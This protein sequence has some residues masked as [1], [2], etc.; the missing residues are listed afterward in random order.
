M[1]KKWLILFL[2]IIGIGASGAAYSAETE[3]TSSFVKFSSSEFLTFD[4][5]LSL[6]KNPDPSNPLAAKLYKFW[7]TPII[8]NEAYYEGV[9]APVRT[10]SKLGRMLRVASWNIEKSLKLKEAIGLLTDSENFAS[11]I[12]S[13]K[14]PV[15]SER[16]EKVLEQHHLLTQADIILCQEM[17]IGVK[18]SG[19]VNAPLE[20]AK[21]LHMNYA[22]APAYLEIDPAY[23]GTENIVLESG[24][25]DE[26]AMDFYRVDK[27]RYKGLFGSVVLSRYPIKSVTVFPLHNQGYDWYWGEQEKTTFFEESRRFGAKTLFQSEVHREMKVGGRNFMRVDLE[28]PGLPDNTLTIINI[29]LEIKCLPVAR[30]AQISEILE[31]IKG[32][33]NPVIMA[34]DFNSAPGDLSPTS[35]VRETARTLKR[36]TTW[37]TVGINAIVPQSMAVNVTRGISNV[38]KNFQNPTAKS[39]PIVAPNPSEKMFKEIE[40]FR[41]DDGHAFDFRGDEKRAAGHTGLLANANQRDRMGFKTSFQLKRTIAEV[42]GKYRLDW[43]FVKSFLIDPRDEN[44][45]YR[46]A[47]H[48]GRILEE[49]NTSLIQPASDHHPGIVDLPF[50]EVKL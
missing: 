30:A 16:Y 22:Y 45:P 41:F 42:I 38:T 21:A 6:S 4:E 7:R 40:N 20:L 1:E 43:F 13:A 18:R 23:L 37:L 3:P 47:P 44:G 33:Q 39:I 25:Q 34:G 24:T 46:F 49:L 17:D 29:H 8:S 19:Y 27:D 31:Y 11:L 5:L 36:P 35:A 28:V 32:I 15:N 9:R 10:D 26:E 50:D 48:F 2:L 14:A 12:D